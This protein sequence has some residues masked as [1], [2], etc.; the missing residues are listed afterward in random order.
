MRFLLLML[1]LTWFT[2]CANNWYTGDWTV[3]DVEFPAVSALSYEDAQAW[4]GSKAKVSKSV[5]LFRDSR[6]DSPQFEH[7]SFTES[8]FYRAYRASY[9]QLG[10]AGDSVEVIRVTCS[11][12]SVFAGNTLIQVNEDVLYIPW[13]GAFFRLERGV[14]SPE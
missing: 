14:S 10:I 6:C 7:E 11:E 9:A 1:S 4:F 2:G 8:E 5:F 3:T 13:D 12:A